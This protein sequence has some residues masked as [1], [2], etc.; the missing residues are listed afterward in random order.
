MFGIPYMSSPPMRSARSKTVT[1]WP[2]RLSWAA[3]ARP[4]GPE[5]T[6]AARLPVRLL[7]ASGWTQP[8]SKPLSAL[9][10]AMVFNV[11]GTSLMPDKP[12]RSHGAGHDRPDQPGE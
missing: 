8:S 11:A 7:G 5:P 9:A 10:H 4:A 1:Q 12:D 2:A 3:A 6:T